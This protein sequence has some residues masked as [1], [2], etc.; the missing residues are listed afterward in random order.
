MIEPRTFSVQ[1]EDQTLMM[2]CLP[3]LVSIVSPIPLFK[4]SLQLIALALSEVFVHILL[5]FYVLPS[6]T[7]L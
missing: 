2:R 1:N 5:G 7:L 3:L 6:Q 4:Y